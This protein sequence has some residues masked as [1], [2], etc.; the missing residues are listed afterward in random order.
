VRRREAFPA[1]LFGVKND[2]DAMGAIDALAVQMFNRA[3]LPVAA[4]LSAEGWRLENGAIGIAPLDPRPPG[5]QRVLAVFGQNIDCCC[6]GAYCPVERDADGVMRFGSVVEFGGCE[7]LLTQRLFQKV[8]AEISGAV[9]HVAAAA[10]A[11]AIRLRNG[12]K[13]K[14]ETN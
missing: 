14:A 2:A 12:A 13:D 4:F 3:I 9:P 7:S 11:D 6:F 5:A 10:I 8:V 1:V